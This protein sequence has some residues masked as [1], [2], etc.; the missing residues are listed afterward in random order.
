MTTILTKVTITGADDSTS[1]NDLVALS[2]QFPFVEWGIL[3]S[4]KSE[5]GYRF[6]SRPWIDELVKSADHRVRE[7][8]PLNLS[9]HICGTWVRKLLIGCLDWTEL[10]SCVK[11]SQRIQIN[12]HG[13]RHFSEVAMMETLRDV[14]RAP[15]T[16][17]Q[18]IF[19]L[20][21]VNDHLAY[22]ASRYGLDVAG[23]HDLS[24]GAGVTPKAWLPP[25]SHLPTGYAGGLSPDNVIEQWHK[26]EDVCERPTWI[27]MERNV[28]TPDDSALDLEKV[29]RVLELC[30]PFTAA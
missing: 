16:N 4:L 2:E 18:I 8:K 23:L 19:Q 25:L 5:G 30:D 14:P 24:A 7:L 1:I 27:D 26:I 22:A 13:E 12:T 11:A 17:K 15:H 10:P 3:V 9:T 29:R 28:R 21:G 20:D 6:P